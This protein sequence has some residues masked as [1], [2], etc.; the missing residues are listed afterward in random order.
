LS[1]RTDSYFNNYEAT[2][3]M[4]PGHSLGVPIVDTLLLDGAVRVNTLKLGTACNFSEYA[5][6]IFLLY[7]TRWL[8]HVHRVDVVWDEYV[9][10]SL[11]EDV[12]TQCEEA[13]E[14]EGAPNLL[15]HY[16]ATGRNF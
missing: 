2:A 3:D 15:V 11:K 13:S 14:V 12:Q 4:Q 1:R 9:R 8:Q 10:G 7:I 6:H 5:S 16:P